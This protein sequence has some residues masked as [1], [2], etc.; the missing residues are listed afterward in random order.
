MD[1]A[2]PWSHVMFDFLSG[3]M[4]GREFVHS[5]F[6]RDSK[7]IPS[8]LCFLELVEANPELVSAGR[9][10][11]SD[12]LCGF[13][14]LVTGTMQRTDENSRSSMQAFE[15]PASQVL[16]VASH[17]SITNIVP[18]RCTRR[19]TAAHVPILVRI[20]GCK[21]TN[22]VKNVMCSAVQFVNFVPVFNLRSQEPLL[23]LVLFFC[24]P[25]CHDIL[26]IIL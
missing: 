26:F 4:D 1:F 16:A 2:S 21:C 19:I 14:L 8:F 18:I 20:F 6:V 11:L 13:S 25:S 23:L 7:I 24:I 17:E 15:V 9:V 5:L 3:K 12:F 22:Y 10:A